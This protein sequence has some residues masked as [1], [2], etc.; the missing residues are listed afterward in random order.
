MTMQDLYGIG[1]SGARA[2][3]AAMGTV[4][5]NIANTDTPG[6]ARRSIEIKESPAGSGTTIFYRSGIGFGGATLGKVVRMNDEYL[7]IAARN[8][9]N[10]LANADQRA[11]WMS[12][13]QTALNDGSLGVGQRMTAMFSA[14]ERLASNPTDTTLRANVLFSF[15]QINTS[16]RQS[17]SDLVAI[18]DSIG[19]AAENE[20]A[21][22]NDAL[23]QLSDANEGL[24]RSPEG[25]AAHVALLDSRDQALAQITK[26]IDV[27]L[28]T[29][30]ND[31]VDVKYGNVDLVQNVSAGVVVVTQAADGTLSYKAGADAASA[32]AIATPTGGS[33]GG[34]AVSAAAVRDQIDNLDT[35]AADYV[36]TINTW[37]TAGETAAGAAGSP[38]LAIGADAGTLSL[39]ISD[40]ADVAGASPSGVANGN[41]VAITSLRG[42]GG[43]EDKWVSII[44]THGNV[45]N[46]T[47][48]EQT[49]AQGRDEMAQAAR[50]D[51]SGVNL[52]REAADLMRF[53][54]AYQACARI[55][56]VANNV[57]DAL[58]AVIR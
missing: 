23:K 46:A 28:T 44:S 2:Y 32:A 13:I 15:E 1:A 8:T 51:V 33:L 57:M 21:A 26:R 35:L 9:G 54:Q 25:T 30:A 22:L 38:L 27:T 45:V 48:A 3:Q 11:R 37:H 55:I 24:R 18:K 5:N 49:A 50:A 20:V 36:Q 58:F 42:G 29:Q 12:D 14:V 17:R 41:L 34:L 31:V 16:F 40:P 10:A 19:K 47:L 4:S 6:Y 56:S 52:D 7:D 43:L 39:L 53:Q